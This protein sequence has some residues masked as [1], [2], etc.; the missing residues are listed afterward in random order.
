MTKQKIKPYRYRRLRPII[1]MTMGLLCFLV[2]WQFQPY[3]QPPYHP[4]S[5][6][7]RIIS[8]RYLE[9]AKSDL[10]S[11]SI[12]Y[13]ATRHQLHSDG[14]WF[15]LPDGFTPIRQNF[16]QENVRVKNYV[17]LWQTIQ[18]VSVLRLD[19]NTGET[20]IYQDTST[21]PTSCGDVHVMR[22]TEWVLVTDFDKRTDLCNILT[23]HRIENLVPVNI[24]TDVLPT[25]ISYELPLW[26]YHNRQ[27]MT[28]LSPDEARIAFFA[29]QYPPSL[30]TRR[31]N[32]VMVYDF[33]SDTLS[34]VATDADISEDHFP[35]LTYG[36]DDTDIHWR[37]NHILH[38]VSYSN[39]IGDAHRNGAVI[40]SLIH[41]DNQELI[42]IAGPWFGETDLGYRWRG[43]PYYTSRAYDE[44][45]CP[46]NSYHYLTY[47]DALIEEKPS[48]GYKPF[49][50]TVWVDRWKYTRDIHR[51]PEYHAGI[52]AI[53]EDNCETDVIVSGEIERLYAVSTDH[54]YVAYGKGTNGKLDNI[55]SPVWYMPD[56]RGYT[57]P[58]KVCLHDREVG[59]DLYC[60]STRKWSIGI[61]DAQTW[62]L[63]KHNP[64]TAVDRIARQIQLSDDGFTTTFLPFIVETT[65]WVEK[66][67]SGWELVTT[68][69]RDST[70]RRL[71]LYNYDTNQFVRLMSDWMNE[72][73]IRMEFIEE[74]RF[75]ITIY[76]ESPHHA[77]LPT[78]DIPRTIYEIELPST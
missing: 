37:N 65:S 29:L 51:E 50:E 74:N 2:L 40:N 58:E 32:Y 39:S 49:D 41:V 69:E 30:T 27:E 20:H 8:T 33:S 56:M 6:E 73:T 46:G 43:C 70:Q 12:V 11:D 3:L 21:I 72:T 48:C 23:G 1:Y 26:D 44:E 38:I 16:R 9:H 78:K 67:L 71:A 17:Y 55:S 35:F 7:I 36:E 75:Q 59:V 64:V 15:D 14:K 10:S 5:D 76:D 66:D 47:H 53:N 54:R 45:T 13:N 24:P 28:W 22:L 57:L 25:D 31:G 62:I 42:A 61:V 34:I 18:P 77:P 52:I 68:N 19:T 63:Q 4:F 60:L